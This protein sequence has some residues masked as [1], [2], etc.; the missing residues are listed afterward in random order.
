MDLKVN[1]T[2]KCHDKDEMFN[3][4]MSLAAEGIQTDFLYYKDGQKGLWLIV[5]KIEGG[6]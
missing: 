4:M 1:D 3:M 2:I 5:Q 6:D